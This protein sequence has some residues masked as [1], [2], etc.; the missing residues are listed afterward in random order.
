MTLFDY[1]KW[2]EA[3]LGHRFT[4]YDYVGCKLQDISEYQDDL[5]FALSRLYWPDFL[6]IDGFIFLKEIFD[7]SSYFNYKQQQDGVEY[8]MNLL[9][10]ENFYQDLDLAVE[11][12]SVL[13]ET[14][15]AKLKLE[16][17]DKQF[18]ID[19]FDDEDFGLTFYQNK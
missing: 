14:W 4:L 9:L 8:W 19:V 6:S 2:K 12:A 3:N 10:T 18:T 5:M 13:K 15:G 7:E 11:F 17:P 1:E 16:F